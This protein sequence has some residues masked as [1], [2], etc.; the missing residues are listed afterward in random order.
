MLLKTATIRIDERIRAT[1]R[2]REVRCDRDDLIVSAE[3]ALPFA[4]VPES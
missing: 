2:T 3:I 1:A 4:A